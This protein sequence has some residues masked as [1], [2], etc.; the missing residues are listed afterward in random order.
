MIVFQTNNVAYF[1]GG[2]RGLAG[3]IYISTAHSDIMV[4][5]LVD[6]DTF[7]IILHL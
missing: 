7:S 3:C 1:G 6:V 2:D 5:V 4:E